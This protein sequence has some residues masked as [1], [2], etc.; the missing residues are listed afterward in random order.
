MDYESNVASKGNFE[1]L[2]RERKTE[3]KASCAELGILPDRCVI[4]ENKDLQDNPRQWWDEDVVLSVLEKHVE[5]WNIDLV[6]NISTTLFTNP[7][8]VT[9]LFIT[10]Q[11]TN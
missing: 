8:R 5:E 11:K 9:F 2:G 1:G 7:H 3:A 10:L 6:R 4:L